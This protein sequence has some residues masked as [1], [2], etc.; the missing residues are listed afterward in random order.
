MRA[1]SD[2]LAILQR[3]RDRRPLITSGDRGRRRRSTTGASRG[4]GSTPAST[5]SCSSPPATCSPA[6]ATASRSR[7]RGAR[8]CI[9]TT[10]RPATNA[11][12]RSVCDDT[13][14]IDVV[15]L[16][17]ATLE[18]SHV[19][20]RYELLG[21]PSASTPRRARSRRRGGG[22]R[23]W[24]RAGPAICGW[25]ATSWLPTTSSSRWR[26]TKPGRR[27]PDRSRDSTRAGP[28]DRLSSRRA[29]GTTGFSR[30]SWPLRRSRGR[31][32]C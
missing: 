21:D 9:W 5:T 7:S 23:R 10:S 17:P 25:P 13:A 31:S 18:V 19:R 32:S 16:A 6:S 11:I 22:S 28:V 29:D 1:R 8:R 24:T 3:D 26:R 12:T 4:C 2:G 15:Y 14:E 27:A 30:P 20:Q